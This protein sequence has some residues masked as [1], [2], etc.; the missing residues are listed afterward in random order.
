[1]QV[2]AKA[3]ALETQTGDRHVGYGAVG[4]HDHMLTICPSLR[5]DRSH[6]AIVTVSGARWGTHDVSGHDGPL[7][8]FV[9]RFR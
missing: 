4:D 1:M 3:A 6:P 2:E 5:D 7:E 9:L 8:I